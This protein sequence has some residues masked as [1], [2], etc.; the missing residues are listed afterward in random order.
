M[1]TFTCL[2]LDIL[3]ILSFIWLF[4]IV[5]FVVVTIVSAVVVCFCV[6]MEENLVFYFIWIINDMSVFLLP[7]RSNLYFLLLFVRFSCNRKFLVL[8][9]N[10]CYFYFGREAMKNTKKGDF[11][12]ITMSLGL[13]YLC[14]RIMKVSF[15]TKHG[16]LCQISP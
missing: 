6:V 1:Q 3:R 16:L 7:R 15:R 12:H 13:F 8:W 5:C 10:F 11:S 9:Y 4:G 14:N 2:W